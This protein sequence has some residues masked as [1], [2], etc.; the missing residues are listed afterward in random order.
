MIKKLKLLWQF[1]KG[2]RAIYLGAIAS[3]AAGAFFAFSAPLVIRYAID[4]VIGKK[5]V[6]DTF[7]TGP[8][9][10]DLL[11]GLDVAGSLFLCSVIFLIASFFRGVCIFLKERL[12]SQAA[13]KTAKNIK[14]T[15]YNHIQRLYF[16]EHSRFETGD[17]VQRCTSDVETVRHFLAMQFVEVGRAL[18]SVA[19]SILIMVF[20]DLRMAFISIGVIPLI[21]GFSFIF[22]V[23]IKQVF[24]DSDEAEG[25]LTTVLQ[26]NLT[27]VRVV[28]AFARQ[29]YETVKFNEKNREHAELTYKLIKLLGWYWS[30][31]DFLCLI[32]IFAVLISGIYFVASGTL[33]IGTLVVFM[34]FVSMLLWPVRQMGRILT[35]MGK[36]I[37]SLGRIEEILDKP[38]EDDESGQKPKIIGEIEFK[39][40]SFGYGNESNVLKNI[41]FKVSA[42]ET[43]AILGATGSG[44]SSIM[45]L[46]PRL[47]EYEKGSITIDGIELKNID[48]KW[49]RQHIGIVLQEPFLFSKTIKENIALAADNIDDST[50]FEAASTAAL[51]D[52]I[53]SFEKG[54]E[55]FVGEKGVTLSGGQK[56]RLAI[57][58]T[59]I[60]NPP[61]LIFDDSLSAVDASTDAQIR[62]SLQK[63]SGKTTTFIISHRIN[64]LSAADRIFVIDGGEI[65][66]SGTH[67]ELILTAGLYKRIYELQREVE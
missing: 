60:N 11:S 52:V 41:S 58:R 56:Q 24:K 31:S 6:S 45:H 62:E 59:I 42:G 2:A 12:S 39:N 23:K 34:S 13:E 53:E 28:R 32:Q 49:I 16:D 19:I 3:V 8:F 22:F 30:I 33:S 65:V 55:T 7:F 48:K 4:N 29:S 5:E 44:K 17:M 14:E 20:L 64:T 1:M 63:R 25:K 18:F 51:H 38:V 67:S 36:A 27:G 50:V 15:L 57:A 21:F 10:R 47:Y 26:E 46:L 43:V 37:I 66:Q 61:I 35:D 54:Y 9:L 40:L